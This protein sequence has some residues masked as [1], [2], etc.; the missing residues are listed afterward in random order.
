MSEQLDIKDVVAAARAGERDMVTESSSSTE[1]HREQEA[2]SSN[3][4]VEAHDSD[5][6][7]RPLLLDQD[8]EMLCRSKAE[9]FWLLGYEQ[10]TA[11]EIWECV[12]HKT[13]KQH[14]NQMHK[15][16]NDILSL[17]VTDFMNY[18]TM[19]AYRGFS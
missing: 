1:K 12:L 15:V 4:T 14:T 16:V 8:I 5:Y 11:E 7:D 6:P 17:K 18:M 2:H 3:N 10:V 19:Q 13:R 9:E